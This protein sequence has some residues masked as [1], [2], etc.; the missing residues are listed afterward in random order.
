MASC[1]HT[2]FRKGKRLLIIFK[3]GTKEVDKFV[4][5]KSGYL[6]MERLG[7]VKLSKVRSTSIL[8]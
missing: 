1:P 2:S 3:D 6:L 5:N 4:G 8:R 7:R